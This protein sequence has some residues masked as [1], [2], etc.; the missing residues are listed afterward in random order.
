MT[1]MKAV[2]CTKYGPPKVLQFTE[3]EKPAPKENEILIK[4]HATSVTASDCVIR[5][6]KMPGNPSFPKK[7]IMQLLM[8]IFLGFSKPRNSILGL[9]LSGEVE[10]IGEA[11]TLFKKGDQVYGFTANKFGTYAE[12][13]CLSEKDATRGY[14]SIKPKNLNHQEATAVVYGGVLAMYFM[15]NVNIQSGQKILI[16][17]ASGAIGTTAIQFAKSFG[18]EVTAICSSSNFELVKSLGS[19][20]VIDYTKEDSIDKL[21]SYDFILDAV[22]KYKSSKLKIAC[23]NALNSIGQYVSVD[24]NLHQLKHDDLSQLKKV[25]EEGNLKAVIDSCYPIEKMIEAHKY[26]EKGHKKGNVIITL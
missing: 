4:T 11:V 18:A 25:I 14:L 9:V 13:K 1:N 10:A 16:Y 15:R 26:V 3:I 23:K 21:T 2:I 12:Y 17:G 7:Q 8:R 20:R 6:F 22:G 24:D 5:G 19:D